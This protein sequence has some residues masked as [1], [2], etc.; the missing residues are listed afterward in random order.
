MSA[1]WLC[2]SASATTGR[3]TGGGSSSS[4]EPTVVS[5]LHS[6]QTV[7]Q[8]H[9]PSCSPAAARAP[10][11]TRAAAGRPAAGC[12]TAAAGHGDQADAAPKPPPPPVTAPTAASTASSSSASQTAATSAPTTSAGRHVTMLPA[13]LSISASVR[14]YYFSRTT[15]ILF[16]VYTKNP[17]SLTQSGASK[18]PCETIYKHKKLKLVLPA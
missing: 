9:A 16:L 18:A 1:A 7:Q 4:T 3:S 8:S 10:C 12:S 2:A 17:N 6:S 15:L 13:R 5:G 14:Q 11:A